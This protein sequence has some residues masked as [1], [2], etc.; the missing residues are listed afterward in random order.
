MSTGPWRGHRKTMANAAEFTAD[1]DFF[2]GGQL[3]P[4]GSKV[5]QYET[6]N[7]GWT[8]WVDPKGEA[9]FAKE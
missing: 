4:K 2:F 8:S 7:F 1:K 5:K 3:I 9:H 6:T